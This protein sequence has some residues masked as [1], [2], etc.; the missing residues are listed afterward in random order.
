M[1]DLQRKEETGQEL[2][3][4]QHSPFPQEHQPTNLSFQRKKLERWMNIKITAN[5]FPVII[6]ELLIKAM[7]AEKKKH[8]VH[9]DAAV[10][11]NNP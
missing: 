1:S 10:W 8:I 11:E 9:K 5:C 7:K 2:N 6:F 4:A 3:R